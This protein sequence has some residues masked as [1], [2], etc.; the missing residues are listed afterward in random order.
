MKKKGGRGKSGRGKTCGKTSRSLV[1]ASATLLLV[2]VLW[3]AAGVW[4][5]Q[6]PRR[7]IERKESTWPAFVVSPLLLVGEPLADI[8]GALGLAGHDVVYEYDTEAPAGA[9]AFAGLPK[10]V[11]APAPDDI[12]TIDRGDFAI[13]WSPKLRHPVWVA[14]HVPAKPAF[15]VADRPNFTKDPEARLSPPASAYARSG[16]DRGHMAPNHAMATRFGFELQRKTFLTSNIA[17]QS[18]SLNRGIWREIEHRIADLWTARWGEIWVVVGCISEN[19][20]ETV[21]GTDIDVPRKFYQV[22]VAQDG[23][24]VRAMALLVEQEVPWRAWPAKYLVTIDELEE[25]SGLDFL[26]DLPG[27]MQ[28]PLE[29]ELPS[30]LWPIRFSDMFSLIAAHYK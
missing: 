17:P 27:F 1:A 13:G 23:M 12:Q 11:G 20:G 22:I 3:C 24:E 29:A 25:L 16:Y 21:S 14:Y 7:W 2:A 9:V 10:R 4:F 15:A 30:R 8:A 28:T 18:P 19:G 5:A 6:H 26:P